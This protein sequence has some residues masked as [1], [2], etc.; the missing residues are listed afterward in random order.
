MHRRVIIWLFRRS[1]RRFSRWIT[2]VKILK[3]SK[4][5]RSG[6]PPRDRFAN[7]VLQFD[8]I[9]EA[10]TL[11]KEQHPGQPGHRQV[12]LYKLDHVTVALFRFEKGGCLRQHKAKRVVL[13]QLVEG[14]LS[15]VAAG[16]NY[17]LRAGGL[18]VLAPQVPHDVEAE[19]ESTMVLTGCQEP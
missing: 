19:E 1:R 10:A 16:E 13:I 6:V 9:A 12:A 18:L 8:L 3:Q 17:S 5:S 2:W 14:R 4:A 7:E 11:A 15:V